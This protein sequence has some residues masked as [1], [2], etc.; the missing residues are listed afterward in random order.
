[1]EL[2]PKTLISA[3]F[4]K[5]SDVYSFTRESIPDDQYAMLSPYLNDFIV[6]WANHFFLILQESSLKVSS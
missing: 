1:M 2:Q 3:D 4:K 6:Y 5:M